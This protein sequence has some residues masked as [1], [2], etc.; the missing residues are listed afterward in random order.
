MKSNKASY[1]QFSNQRSVGS[2]RQNVVYEGVQQ[3][4]ADEQN[5]MQSVEADL[6]GMQA[7]ITSAIVE[8]KFVAATFQLGQKLFVP[9][10]NRVPSR[11]R[12]I[13]LLVTYLILNYILGV[14]RKYSTQVECATLCGSKTFDARVL[15]RIYYEPEQVG[16]VEGSFICL[17]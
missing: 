1:S 12:H 5:F 14:D 6:G 3:F 16:L 7:E 8:D 2:F 10:N 17:H 11:V 9:S 15:A 13:V 4:A